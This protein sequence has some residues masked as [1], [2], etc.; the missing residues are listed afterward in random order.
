[1]R[2][3]P[4]PDLAFAILPQLGSTAAEKMKSFRLAIVVNLAVDLQ[5]RLLFI[6]REV[7]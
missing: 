5:P 1:M 4:R 7:V 2:E 6:R 3:T